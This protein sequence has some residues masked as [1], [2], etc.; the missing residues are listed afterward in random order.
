LPPHAFN[1]IPPE[2]RKIL[3][4]PLD[5]S[6]EK[7]AEKTLHMHRYNGTDYPLLFPGQ[8]ALILDPKFTTEDLINKIDTRYTRILKSILREEEAILAGKYERQLD[9]HD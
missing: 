9:N 2:F 6:E 8:F 7:A 3:H 4:L 1:F 5:A